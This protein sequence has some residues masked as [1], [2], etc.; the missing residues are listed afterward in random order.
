MMN[1]DNDARDGLQKETFRDGKLSAVGRYSNGKK[2]GV[3]KFYFRNGSLRATGKLSG[4][5]A[6]C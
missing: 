3:W 5:F 6:P 2:T 4:K 1:A